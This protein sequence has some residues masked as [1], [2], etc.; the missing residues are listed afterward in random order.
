LF[1]ILFIIVLAIVC[2]GILHIPVSFTDELSRSVYIIMV[3]LGAS[4]ALRDRS[5]VTVDIV[6]NI[7]PEKV[8]RILRIVSAIL[9]I[10]FIVAMTIGATEDVMRYWTSVISTVGWL[11]VGYLY[12]GVA[13]SGVLMIFYIILNLIDDIRNRPVAADK[14]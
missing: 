1:S 8:K 4:V 10:P 3:F 13:I 2:R 5:H 6:T 11:K 12:L 14:G 9:T 7:V